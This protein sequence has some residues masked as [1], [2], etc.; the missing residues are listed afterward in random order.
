MIGYLYVVAKLILGGVQEEKYAVVD[1]TKDTYP[2]IIE[3]TEVSRAL[4]EIY[5]G[6]VVSGMSSA[7]CRDADANILVHTSRT[8]VHRKL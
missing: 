6:G 1:V 5:E 3:E 7:L 2:V 8:D 4:F